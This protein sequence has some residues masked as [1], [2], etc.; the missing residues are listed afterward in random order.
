MTRSWGG[1]QLSHLVLWLALVLGIASVGVW[2]GDFGPTYDEGVQARYGELALRYFE[3]GGEDRS[4]NE[5]MDLRF[6]G[7]L[8]E[9][10]PAL[11]YGVGEAG[12]SGSS[13]KYDTRHLF[14]GLLAVLSLPAVWLYGRLFGDPRIAA[15]SLLAVATMPRLCGHAFNNSKD[16][17][18]VVVVLWFMYAVAALFIGARIRWRAVVVCG[19]AMGLA[20]CSRPGGFPVF[21]VFLAAGAAI[22][23]LAREHG[24]GEADLWGAVRQLL[25]RMLV[26]LLIAWPIM[27]APWPWA[28]ESVLLH[29]LEAMRVAAKFASTVLV[30]FEGSVIQSDNLPWNYV[31]KHVLI[32]TPPTVLSLALLGLI[33]GVRTQMVAWRSAEA[34]MITLTQV[35]LLLPIALFALVRPNVYGGMR[36]FLF[37]LPPLGVLAA[38]GAAR[39]VRAVRSPGARSVAW[40]ALFVVLCLPLRDVV[41]LHPYQMTYYNALVGGIEGAS[42]DYWTDYSMTSYREAIGWVNAQAAATPGR[43][44]VVVIAAPPPIM[45]WAAG[46]AAPNVELV[47][48]RSLPTKRRA[49][50]PADFYIGSTRRG[51]DQRFPQA[52]IVHTIGRDG[53]VFTAIRG[54]PE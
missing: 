34:R 26:V 53:A 25:P 46:Y 8:F 23:L 51:L 44:V 29:P 48:L 16:T 28:H 1:C 37:V 43:D 3:T 21:A 54:R 31:A 2:H 10:I 50:A 30:L 52:P 5:Y 9:M 7:P 38:Y 6:Y 22:W 47:P 41:R 27:V 45:L 42:D 20:L 14:M 11:V 15:F 17:S 39:V 36:H 24:E 13:S 49:L 40:A 18:F 4:C 32:V 12:V 19:V 33:L 35:W